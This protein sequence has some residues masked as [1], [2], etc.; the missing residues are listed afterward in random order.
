MDRYNPAPYISFGTNIALNKIFYYSGDY[1]E[2]VFVNIAS[3][4]PFQRR[5]NAISIITEDSQTLYM[6]SNHIYFVFNKIIAG[7]DFS[8]IHKVFVSDTFMYP[9]ADA[10]IS[11]VARN[12]FYFD[13]DQYGYLRVFT[14]N[15]EGIKRNNVY[16]LDYNLNSVSQIKGFANNYEITTVRF[17]GRRAYIV[18]F[19]DIT[20]YFVV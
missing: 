17:V 16:N 6:S 18:L 12:Q 2:P 9:T 10:L 8:H 19:G 13:E 4:N 3:A 20:P 15:Q 1:T 14:S 11:G 7:E 5:I